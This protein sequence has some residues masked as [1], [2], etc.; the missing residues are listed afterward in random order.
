M[1]VLVILVLNSQR[2]HIGSKHVGIGDLLFRVYMRIKSVVFCLMDRVSAYQ[3]NLDEH[4]GILDFDWDLLFRVLCDYTVFYF[5]FLC[6]LVPMLLGYL[7]FYE[8][9][10]RVCV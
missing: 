1:T 8:P 4:V 9:S 6:T 7:D 2:N 3:V 10:L 5:G